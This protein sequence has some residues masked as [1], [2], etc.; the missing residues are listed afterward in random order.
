MRA[1]LPRLHKAH[2]RIQQVRPHPST[3]AAATFYQRYGFVSI[4]D[5]PTRLV[6]KM[7][8]IEAIPGLT[9]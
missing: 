5:N 7:S 1:G 6:Q 4:P 3:P 9:D 2:T 8:D